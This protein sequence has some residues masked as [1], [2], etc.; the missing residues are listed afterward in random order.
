M[1]ADKNQFFA[2]ICDH[3]RPS[4]ANVSGS[5]C[6]SVVSGFSPIP[7]ITLI[8]DRLLTRVCA[9]VCTKGYNQLFTPTPTEVQIHA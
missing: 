7:A 9:Y 2:F 6:A 5:S 1:N 8:S 4:P 3:L